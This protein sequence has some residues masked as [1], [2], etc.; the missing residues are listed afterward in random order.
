MRF[1]ATFVR[2]KNSI[3]R[4][5]SGG[6]IRCADKEKALENQGLLSGLIWLRGQDLNLR[7]SGYE[8]DLPT[9]I[10]LILLVFF[11]FVQP[12]CEKMSESAACKKS[13]M[14]RKVICRHLT[15][16][17]TMFKQT[18]VNTPSL[19]YRQKVSTNL[20]RLSLLSYLERN[21][22]LHLSASFR[23]TS[24]EPPKYCSTRSRS[25]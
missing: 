2:Y 5:D 11:N 17:R 1:C 8:T 10:W 21:S 15:I 12:L 23:Y 9:F 4:P 13:M 6:Q 7:P 18:Q 22:S 20:A 14:N 24:S 19:L 3:S 25:S 16:Y